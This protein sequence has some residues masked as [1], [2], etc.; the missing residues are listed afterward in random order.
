MAT[1]KLEILRRIAAG[2]QAVE[3]E[4]G[5]ET[6]DQEQDD[7]TLARLQAIAGP[8]RAAG[9]EPVPERDVGVGTSFGAGVKEGFLMPLTVF[10]REGQEVTRDETSEKVAGFV[11]EMVGLGIGFVPFSVGT[12]V[13]L[14]GVGLTS[15]LAP[16]TQ[17]A[18]HNTLGGTFQAVGTVEEAEDIP[19]AAAIGAGLGLSVELLFFN[20]A[21]RG[22]ADKVDPKKTVDTG[23][24][25]NDELVPAEVLSEEY[26]MLPRAA[27]GATETQAK[28]TLLA[29][30]NLSYEQVLA[31]LTDEFQET[32]ILPNVRNVEEQLGKI[33]ERHANAQVITR[34]V[35]GEGTDILIHNPLFDDARLTSKQ[36][37]QWKTHGVFEDMGVLYRG[38][39]YRATGVPV[40][41]GFVQ[42]KDLTRPLT[43]AARESEVVIP[44]NP[45]V[46]G[47]SQAR[48][49]R[50]LELIQSR[51][52]IGFTLEAGGQG[53][54]RRGVVKTEDFEEV[55]SLK[56]FVD[57]HIGVLGQIE[58]ASPDEALRILAGRMGVKGLIE[59]EEG[60]VKNVRVFDQDAVSFVR[61]P[62]R[63]PTS[64]GLDPSVRLNE[65]G[66]LHSFTP[67]WKNA[68]V[69]PLRRA[70][71]PEKEINVVLERFAADINQRLVGIMDDEIQALH[72]ANLFRWFG[73]CL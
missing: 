71:Y 9:F 53:G 62:P 21:M 55:G 5:A 34:S 69:A 38:D 64:V 33:A 40:E 8:S 19:A 1:N 25:V 43:F 46:L 65:D 44:T 6:G 56:E 66:T 22:R 26:L 57:E 59:T 37:Q 61:E 29:D 28:V 12:G 67:T 32:I 41:P 52:E 47:Q 13:V 49:A 27:E 72:R 70:G 63:G 50:A 54:I 60:V 20:R 73:G 39:V 3:E 7:S 42:V 51:R 17:R 24:P 68:L 14:K 31:G 45:R 30:E 36:I 4:E 58:A 10:G 35:K 23:S 48:Q 2:D 16:A 15:K 18:V 11:G